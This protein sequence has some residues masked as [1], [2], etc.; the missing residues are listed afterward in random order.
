MN[1]VSTSWSHFNNVIG[2]L[3]RCEQDLQTLIG[4]SLSDDELAAIA[5]EFDRLMEAPDYN[6]YDT[7]FAFGMLVD[8]LQS[9]QVNRQSL[10]VQVLIEKYLS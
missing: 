1:K 3:D 5:T 10:L 8:Y 4:R 9:P 2:Q 7:Y 6:F